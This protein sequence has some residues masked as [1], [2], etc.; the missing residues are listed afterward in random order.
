MKN[1]N[2][3][4]PPRERVSVAISGIDRS[5]PDDIVLDG[6]CETLHNMRY[7]AE[8]WRPVHP[9][10]I[11]KIVPNLPLTHKIVYKHPA[12]PENI[13]I[14][15]SFVNGKYNYEAYDTSKMFAEEGAITPLVSRSD[16]QMSISHFGNVLILT[17]N[18]GVFY[19]LYK[20]GKYIHYSKP[21][22]PSFTLTTE[23]SGQKKL[24]DFVQLSA[25][26]PNFSDKSN[27]QYTGLSKDKW[28]SG[29]ALGEIIKTLKAWY[30]LNSTS[31]TIHCLWLVSDATDGNSLL[32]STY[33]DM[34]GDPT[35]PYHG[36]FALFA[37]YRST[38][39]A[40]VS[41]SP[42]HICCSNDSLSGKRVVMDCFFKEGSVGNYADF[43]ATPPVKSA[44]TTYIGIIAD[45]DS[46]RG[47][48]TVADIR[49]HCP[50][51]Y[52]NTRVDIA[53]NR[54]NTSVI[55]SVALYAT[56]LNPIFDSSFYLQDIGSVERRRI[57]ADNKL[58]EQ[59]FYCLWEQMLDIDDEGDY[60]DQF[61]VNID[62]RM[63]ERNIHNATYVPPISHTL[64]PATS[65]DFNNS[66]HIGDVTEVLSVSPLL[67]TPVQPVSIGKITQAAVSV[68]RDNSTYYVLGDSYSASL[69]PTFLPPFNTIIS[70][71]DANA[72]SFF[73][74][75]NGD[76]FKYRLNSAMANNF[77]YLCA[78]PTDEQKYGELSIED[79]TNTAFP[80]LRN[81]IAR[82]NMLFVSE[83]NDC[84]T[85]SFSRAYRIGSNSNRII[86]L[87]SAAIEMPEMKVGE[88]PLYAFTEEGIYALLAGSDTLYARISPVNYDKIINPNTLA[89]NGAIV[90]ITEK[91]VHMLTSQG[92]QVIST[93]IHDKANRPPLD[94]LRTCTMIYPKEHTEIILHNEDD[95]RGVAYVYNIN[96]GYWSTR[97]LKG[98]KLNTDELYNNNTLYDLA[99]EDES[100]ALPVEIVTRPIKL[101]DVEFKR[102][103]TIIPRMATTTEEVLMDISVDGSVD[104]SNYRPLRQIQAFDIVPNSANPL[105]LR[106]TPF[107]AKYFKCK[108]QLDV[109]P[110][111]TTFN[112]SITHIDIEWYKKLRHRM[113]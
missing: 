49:E 82:D 83:P 14:V 112:A 109:A 18:S 73:L 32:P 31:I 57:W 113:R 78:P 40:I 52:V 93:P 53:L 111:E 21:A 67:S 39:G 19:Y 11:S 107:S 3:T 43:I 98:R 68:R 42:L 25:T 2:V 77:A 102:L 91:G 106:R 63:L 59:P 108:M 70:Y 85:F 12:A 65:L 66:L 22:P 90:Y 45:I 10:M 29:E 7:E 48:I 51:S 101:G 5:T 110:N 44:A 33:Q 80:S 1:N 71:P 50:I 79:V 20:D 81:T 95:D 27:N 56:R 105:I 17:A 55:G 76:V 41:Q 60:V 36:E 34:F 87:Q 24:P 96:T 94:F 61:T 9:Y 16:V 84:T 47:T 72:I 75:S 58:P 8:A 86:A 15:E 104:G 97:D 92:T 100:K 28:Y 64:M 74:C 23:E 46:A 6:K 69:E 35:P 54:P 62:A 88:M 38:N 30:T 99:N 13:Y 26:V 89:I 103:E 37:A 4:S